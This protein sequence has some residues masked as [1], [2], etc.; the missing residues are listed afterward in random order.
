MCLWISL[1][2]VVQKG[3]DIIPAWIELH[4]PILV[5]NDYLFASQVF[6]HFL[7]SNILLGIHLI[8][9][10][11]SLKNLTS[12]TFLKMETFICPFPTCQ[13]DFCSHN[14]SKMTIY[15]SL[16]SSEPSFGF[17]ELNQNPL[18]GAFFST[19]LSSLDFNFLLPIFAFSFLIWQ[20]KFSS[21]VLLRTPLITNTKDS[22]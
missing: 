9:L 4:E 15:S 8:S 14:S 17:M 11:Y 6:T 12:F 16:M 10:A 5:P 21:N 13:Q 2:N 22:I 20:L 3:N 19:S 7:Y 18:K 1:V